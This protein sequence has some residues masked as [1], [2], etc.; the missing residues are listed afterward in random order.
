MLRLILYL[1]LHH[2]HNSINYR[3]VFLQVLYFDRKLAERAKYV[4]E[5]KWIS[6]SLSSLDEMSESA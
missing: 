4:A 3:A 2:L 5:R 1:K 6:D